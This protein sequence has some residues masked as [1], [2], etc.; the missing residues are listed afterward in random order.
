MEARHNDQAVSEI[1]VTPDDVLFE[2]PLCRKGMVIDKSAAGMIVDCPQ[3][4]AEVIVPPDAAPDP[5][6][7]QR[8][9][10]HELLL[11][12]LLGA[13]QTGNL[14][15]LNEALALGA[16]VNAARSDGTT[17]LMF[18]VQFGHE[19]VVRALVER[20]AQVEAKRADGRTA[21]MIAERAGHFHIIRILWKAAPKPP[22]PTYRFFSR[23]RRRR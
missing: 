14:A 12:S 6:A 4:H 16:E 3:C 13:A 2:C 23:R 9:K 11:E 7:E 22:D 1:V 20:G 17:A 15:L 21:V 19:D 8:E 10:A 18:A 5:V